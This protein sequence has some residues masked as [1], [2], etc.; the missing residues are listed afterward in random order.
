M[1]KTGRGMKVR[2]EACYGPEDEFV[3]EASFS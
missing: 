1:S 2:I 3:R